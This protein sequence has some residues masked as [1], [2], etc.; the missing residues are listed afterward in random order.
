[1]RHSQRNSSQPPC[2]SYT[3]SHGSREAT[4]F[5]YDIAC[6]EVLAWHLCR[7]GWPALRG[8]SGNGDYYIAVTTSQRNGSWWPTPD[9]TLSVATD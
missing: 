3:Y 4:Q 5:Q 8:P 7:R 6:E 1:M 9:Y 2:T